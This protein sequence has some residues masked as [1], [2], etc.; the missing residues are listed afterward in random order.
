MTGY[1]AA[2]TLAVAGGGALLVLLSLGCMREPPP[3]LTPPAPPLRGLDFSADL[4]VSG[5][6][7]QRI[8]TT[9][10]IK[11]RRSVPATLQFPISCYGLL[12]A[13]DGIRDAPVWEQEPGEGCPE[14]PA[15]LSLMPG[16]EREVEIPTVL[17]R[18]V[19]GA[20]LPD[21]SYRFTVLLVPDG[22]VLEIVAGEADL[23][24]PRFQRD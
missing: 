23:Q 13:Y 21:G 9:V 12:R 10:E 4:D 14:E 16:E 22:N 2:R 19:L 7:P 6:S 5:R 1:G 18:D 17:A 15:S 20:A 11:N 24:R 3:P 8:E